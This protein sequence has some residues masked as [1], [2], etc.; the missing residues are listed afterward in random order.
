MTR[1]GKLL[2]QSAIAA[3][4]G[5]GAIATTATTA[6]A[7]TVCNRYGDCWQTTHRYH[8]PIHLSVRYRDG[9]DNYWRHHHHGYRWHDEGY[10]DNGYWDNS[11]GRYT[12]GNSSNGYWDNNSSWHN[13]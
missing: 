11:G 5:V 4:I 7:Y 9:S 3:L 8:F 12:N 1:I 6:S 2:T 10:R 13:Y